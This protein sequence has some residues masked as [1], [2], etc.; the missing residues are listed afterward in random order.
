M[1]KIKGLDWENK[2]DGERRRF[3]GGR[4][5]SDKEEQ[6]RNEGWKRASRRTPSL[7]FER[8]NLLMKYNRDCI[9]NAGQVDQLDTEQGENSCSWKR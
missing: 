9:Q 2:E 7:N 6:G 5:G 4:H 3:T 8:R 1:I